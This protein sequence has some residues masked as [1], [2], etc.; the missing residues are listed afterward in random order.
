MAGKSR[1]FLVFRFFLTFFFFIK[2]FTFSGKKK[3]K[4]ERKKYSLKHYKSV[5]LM[6]KVEFRRKK[7]VTFSIEGK[8]KMKGKK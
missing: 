1:I 7:F 6:E 8:N 5:L 2:S 3:R 4:Q